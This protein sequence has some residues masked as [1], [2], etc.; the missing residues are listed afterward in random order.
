MQHPSHDDA[1][2]G[3]EPTMHAALRHEYGDP[4]VVST[5]IV[6]RPTPGRGQVLVKV[7]AAGLDRATLHLMT[8]T[9]YLAR[10]VFG[11]RRPHQPVLGMQVAGVVVGLG[12]GVSQFAIGDRV[13]GMATSGSF[14][15]YAVAKASVLAQTPD[16]IT[17]EEASTFGVSA[18]TA[19]E[20]VVTK[21]HVSAGQKV[22]IIGASGAVGAY[23]VQLASHLGAEVTAVA[24]AP[25][26]DFVR[27]LGA[28]HAV[29]YR[30]TAITDL[31]DR[32]DVV[33]DVAGNRK[34]SELRSVLTPQGTLL[35]VGGEEGGPV[36]G[37]L[38]R[39]MVAAL[40]NM[41]TKQTLASVVSSPTTSSLTELADAMAKASIHPQ[42]DRT[43]GLDGVLGAIESMVRG[44]LQGHVVVT[45]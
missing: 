43:V 26:L 21:G 10:L 37:G 4:S 34:L 30:T 18:A 8:G 29:D 5:G 38:Q 15:E 22:L 33:I 41:F 6:P 27:S 7:A 20:A 24:S 36:L 42:F 14:A 23:A 35:L 11:M 32:F 39:N 2:H 25:K 45:P 12:E 19:Y 3:V 13:F 16:S 44:E 40:A 9:P 17:D 1:A 28:T 31:D